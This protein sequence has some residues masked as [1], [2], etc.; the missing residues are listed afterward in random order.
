MT[1][2]MEIHGACMH[3]IAV[4][5]EVRQAQ[6][7]WLIVGIVSAVTLGLVAVILIL[8]HRRNK[9]KDK[10]KKKVRMNN[11]TDRSGLSAS[12]EQEVQSGELLNEV[13]S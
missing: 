13:K 1:E 6:K 10:K 5:A 2:A 8:I 9:R 4:K 7:I 11:N 12:G 3:A